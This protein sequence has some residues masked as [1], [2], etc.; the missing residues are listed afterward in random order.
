M[1]VA[2]ET[3]T[4]TIVRPGRKKKFSTALGSTVMELNSVLKP[5]FVFEPPLKTKSQVGLPFLNH[6][7]WIGMQTHEIIVHD[8]QCKP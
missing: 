6:Q 1:R 5:S 3:C 8:L 2:R 7:N 4:W